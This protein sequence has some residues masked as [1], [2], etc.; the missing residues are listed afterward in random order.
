MK[1]ISEMDCCTREQEAWDPDS[2]YLIR[3]ECRHDVPK[4]HFK[5]RIGRTLS[6]KRL[7]ASF[8]E[9]GHLDIAKVIRRVQRGGVHP[10]IKGVVWEFLLGCYDPDSTFDERTQLRQ[11]RRL[12]YNTLKSKCKEMEPTVGSGRLITAAMITED[13]HPIDNPDGISSKENVQPDGYRND[14]VI[15]D[16]EVIQ[17]KLTLQQIGL[18]VLR[19]DR[20]LIYYE[21]QENQARLWDILAVYSW[22]DKDI[23]YC[24]GE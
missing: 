7:H 6:A 20:V 2:Y 3:P 1:L 21:D 24:Q 5:P 4:T 10:T 8:S 13:G 16:K 9:D 23:G 22:V 15:K 18:D 12:E 11:Q 17:W 19:T 14:N